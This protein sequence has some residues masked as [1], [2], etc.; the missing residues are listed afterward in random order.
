M[1]YVILKCGFLTN[2]EDLLVAIVYINVTGERKIHRGIC[3]YVKHLLISYEVEI[4]FGKLSE[5]EIVWC[6]IKHEKES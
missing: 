1:W 2:H 6:V 3:I 5:E 4:V